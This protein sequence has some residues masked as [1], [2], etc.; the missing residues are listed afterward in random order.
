MSG[1]LFRGRA[2]GLNSWHAKIS[3][4]NQDL[5]CH[6]PYSVLDQE[7]A[8]CRKYTSIS[9]QNSHYISGG[10]AFC[11]GMA[12]F[13]TIGSHAM[14]AQPNAGTH[15]AESSARSSHQQPQILSSTLAQSEGYEDRDW[16]ASY[17][18]NSEP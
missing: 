6:S 7:M 17:I 16:D 13:T 3:S 15:Q 12:E 2:V 8:S 4:P 5:S 10:V 11:C 18:V 9:V 14:S 1:H